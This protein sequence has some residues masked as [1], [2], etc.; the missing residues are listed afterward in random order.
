LTGR[1]RH[2]TLPQERNRA[3]STAVANNATLTVNTMN[4]KL[5]QVLAT[6]ALLCAPMQSALAQAHV[7]ESGLHTLRASVMPSN[8]LSSEAARTHGIPVADDHGVLNV[9]VLE[10]RQGDERSVPAQISAIR[11]DLAG[12]AET[13]AMQEV[14]ANSGVSCIGNFRVISSP[15]ARFHIEALPERNVQALSVELEERFFVPR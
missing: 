2:A 6:I 8:R 3:T 14:R 7:S 12:R 4:S 9:V 13:I 1:Q 10:R 15:T 11:T 5:V